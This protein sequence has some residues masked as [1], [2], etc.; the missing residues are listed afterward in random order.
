MAFNAALLFSILTV[1]VSCNGQNQLPAKIN[2]DEMTTTTT[3]I[4]DTVSALGE[5]IDG[6]FQDK[7]SNYWFASNGEGIYHYDGKVIRHITD[8]NG[9]CNNFVW[10][11]QQDINGIFWFS[12]RDG[13]CRFDGLSFADYTDTVKNAAKGTL[14]Y[15]KGGLFFNHLDGICFFDGE[16]FTNFTI[17]PDT[18]EPETTNLNRPYSVYST[19]AEDSGKVWFGTQEKGVCFYDGKTFSWLNGK[20]LDG[21]AVR[22]IFQDKSGNLWFGNNGGGLFRYDGKTLANITEERGLGN[23]EF[24]KGRQPIDKTGTLARVWAINEDPEGNLWIGTI[25]SG[26]WK[27][28]GAHLTNYTTKDGLPGNAVWV[29]YKD[30]KGALWFVTNGDTVGRFDGQTFQK[31]F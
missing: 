26:L 22:S 2:F 16:S 5:N 30:Q 20:D 19:L 18:Y 10:T 9:L 8:K 14:H 12:T 11:I 23:P 24:L 27:Y 21:P 1:F 17:H 15:R 4:G 31:V 13:I 29:I 7:N 3:T 28:D 6:I 25:D